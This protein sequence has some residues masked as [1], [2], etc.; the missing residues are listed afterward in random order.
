MKTRAI[1]THAAGTRWLGLLALAAVLTAPPPVAAQAPAPP[2]PAPAPAAPAP[3][4]APQPLQVR[5]EARVL[6]WTVANSLDFDFAVR[7]QGGEGGILDTADL[8]LPADP[9]LGSAAR[10]FFGNMNVGGGTFEGVIE[11]LKTVGKVEV[12]SQPSIVLTS[13]NTPKQELNA[14]AAPTAYEAKLSNTTKVPY[15]TTQAVGTTLASVTEYRDSEGV[16]ME[17]SVPAVL[18]DNLV[19]LDL[20]T[21]VNALNGFIRI[22]ANER[23]QSMRVPMI[24]QRIIKNRLI[25][26]DRTVCIAGLMKTHNENQRNR[27]IPWISELPVVSWF[28]SNTRNSASDSELVFLVKPEIQTPYRILETAQQGGAR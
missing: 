12:L 21:T 24:D 3:A 18:D 6:E 4:P 14:P 19:V 26:P 1:L 20:Y 23:N 5:I 13:K 10:L 17:V 22:G 27:G 7:F 25:V 16:T 8:T 2:A 11:A 15:E 9:A 28:L